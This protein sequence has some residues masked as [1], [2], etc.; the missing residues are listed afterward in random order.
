MASKAINDKFDEWKLRGVI[1]SESFGRGKFSSLSYHKSNLSL[2]A[3]ETMQL[4]V[5]INLFQS[6]YS[7]KA[8]LLS[9]SV[10]KDLN[11]L[12]YFTVLSSF[13]DEKQKP[14]MNREKCYQ[15]SVNIEI[16]L[17]LKVCYSLVTYKINNLIALR[18]TN[19]ITEISEP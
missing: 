17:D 15:C 9:K 4:M 19:H 14:A 18:S 8:S 2:I 16:S 10:T 1:I 6:R 11:V 5:N 13:F 7:L 12:P 3:R